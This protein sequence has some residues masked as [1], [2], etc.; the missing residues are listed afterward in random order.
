MLP[1]PDKAWSRKRSIS[2]SCPV[3]R[4]GGTVHIVIN[5]QV[6]FTTDPRDARSTPYCT[7][8][9][10]LVECPVFHVNGD[11]PEAVCMVCQLALEF[12]NEWKRDVFVDMYCFRRHGHN[13]TDEPSFTQPT[14]YKAIAAHPLVSAIYTEQ[15]VKESS[16]TPA[17]GEAITTEYSA[18]LEENLSKAKARE[19]SK[20]AKGAKPVDALQ[21]LDR[22]VPTRFPLH[23]GVHRGRRGRA[24]QSDQGPHHGARRLQG[25][26][27]DQ[28]HPRRPRR[29]RSRPAVRSTGASAKP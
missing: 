15:L 11:D 6:G 9:A 24:R 23:S 21:G 12:R 17:Q 5:N 2:R 29:A 26:S 20:A 28:A 8:V 19:A 10:K 22:R 1:W 7:D 14:L 16:L 4:T 3:Y 25:K 27:Q 13:E 18:A